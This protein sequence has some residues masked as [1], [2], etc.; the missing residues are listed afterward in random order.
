MAQG[1]RVPWLQP[2]EKKAGRAATSPGGPK[3]AAEQEEVYGSSAMLL[4]SRY[5]IV[6]RPHAPRARVIALQP[7]LH[8]GVAMRR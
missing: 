6:N 8:E 2:R 3:V 4:R 7:R 5:R 1:G